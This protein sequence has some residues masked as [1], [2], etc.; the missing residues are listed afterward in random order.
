FWVP[1]P[2]SEPRLVERGYNQAT[3]LARELA[4]AT[5]SPS[6][7]HWLTRKSQQQQSGLGRRERLANALTAFTAHARARV[8]APSSVVL[9][10]DV[11]TTGATAL[12]CVEALNAAGHAVTAIVTLTQ[13]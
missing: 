2:L 9:V 6:P 3:L 10:D 13:A 12:A 11:L 1:V 5:C 4:I 8:H 7:C